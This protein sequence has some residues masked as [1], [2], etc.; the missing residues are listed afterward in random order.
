MAATIAHEINNPLAAATNL[1]YLAKTELDPDANA[2]KYLDQADQ[3]LA[4]VAHITQQ[5]LGFYRESTAPT[6]V[7][8]RRL[9][10]GV[11]QI[12]HKKF[13]TRQIRVEQ[14]YGSEVIVEAIEGEIRQVLSNVI[15]NAADAVPVG[16]MVRVRTSN[17][18]LKNG[19]PA[20][21]ILVADNGRG[22][23]TE[24]R[25]HVF[26]P[27]YTTKDK[28]GT[29]LGLWVTKEIIEKHGGRVSFR[30]RLEGGSTGTVFS[31]LLPLLPKDRNTSQERTLALVDGSKNSPSLETVPADSGKYNKAA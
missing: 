24:H 27:F 20:L 22:I 21:R 11:L 16:G 30:S 10:Q 1:V 17:A 8:I 5:T 18:L 31:I 12:Y 25:G 7:D 4:R 26:E 6:K 15:T 19:D 13:E 23:S 9:I 2:R 3:E 29:G 14:E 28:V